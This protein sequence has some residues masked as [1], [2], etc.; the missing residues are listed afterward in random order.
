MYLW[1]IP[2]S[3]ASMRLHSITY[4]LQFLNI[5]VE[6]VPF[7][8]IGEKRGAGSYRLEVTGLCRDDCL[9]RASWKEKYSDAHEIPYTPEHKAALFSPFS[10]VSLSFSSVL[11]IF[12]T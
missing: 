10:S 5:N 7:L 6:E 12:G 11:P 4:S 1:K 8:K 2:L 9:K 3:P